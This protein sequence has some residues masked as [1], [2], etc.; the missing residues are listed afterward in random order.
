ML[1]EPVRYIVLAEL[2]RGEVE[3]SHDY[4]RIGRV[5]LVT[6]ADQ[7]KLADHRCCPFVAIDEGVVPRD[8]E[9]IGSSQCRCIRFRVGGEVLR[10]SHRT[11]E[12]AGIA[13]SSSAAMLG[14][15]IAVR[16]DRDSGLDPDPLNHELLFG[17]FPKRAAAAHHDVTRDLHLP[18]DLAIGDQLETALGPHHGERRTH[19]DTE[20]SKKILRQDDPG[21][22]A[23]LLNLNRLVH[24][25]VL[26]DWTCYVHN[27]S[28]SRRTA[29][30]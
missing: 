3:E 12:C 6:V 25:L 4:G 18:L 27:R 19:L 13:G 28:L 15:L 1:A 24:T 11:R 10:P 20:M 23:D 21:G 22:V 26:T 2:A 17:E 14:E 29:T 8:A 30:R 5:Q 16:G 9:R 7:K